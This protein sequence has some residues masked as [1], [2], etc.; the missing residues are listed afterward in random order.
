MQ[1]CVAAAPLA[2][3]LLAF[4]VGKAVVDVSLWAPVTL[5]GDPDGVAG[6]GFGLDP[7]LPAA[8]LWVMS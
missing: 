4:A 1:V 3:Q 8:V 6:S 2:V 5:M 7:V